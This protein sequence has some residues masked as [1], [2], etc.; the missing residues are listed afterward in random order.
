M[1]EAD[2][3]AATPTPRTRRS[4]AEDLRRLGVCPGMTLLVHSSIRA[5]G[6]VAGGPVAVIQALM[7]SLTPSGTLVMPAHSSDL[8]DPA[9]W[10]NPPVPAEW[11]DVIRAEMPPFDPRYTPTRAMGA[12][13]ELFRTW[14]EVLRSDHPTTSFAAW[15]QHATLV[16]ANQHL[17]ALG[18]QSPLGK[19]YALDGHVLLLGVG[20]DRN[21]SFHLAESRSLAAREVRTGAPITV[22]GQRKWQWYMEK[23]LPEELFDLVQIGRSFETTGQVTIGKVGSAEARLFGQR[24]AVDFA[25]TW[26]D[27]RVA[28]ST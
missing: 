5:I 22:H 7:D 20:F 27:D 2:L 8:S 16:T 18:D 12:I 10:Q 9:L 14:P 24:A 17:G 23:E 25:S 4:L 1:S 26:I 28:A 6:W 11:V 19:I 13:A 21:T 3:I 15:G